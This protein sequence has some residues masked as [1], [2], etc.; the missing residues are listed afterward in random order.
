MFQQ[1]V[2]KTYFFTFMESS[3]PECIAIHALLAKVTYIFCHVYALLRNQTHDFGIANVML[4][5]TLCLHS[6]TLPSGSGPCAPPRCPTANTS[7]VPLVPLAQCL[8]AWLALS[9]L[10]D[11]VCLA[12]PQVQRRPVYPRGRQGCPCPFCGDCRLF[13]TEK[14]PINA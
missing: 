6:G 9:S 10:C 14:T 13:L 2:S 12:S 11:S 5:H 4:H 3:I 7:V 8:G 1:V